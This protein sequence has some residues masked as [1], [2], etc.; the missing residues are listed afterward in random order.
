MF[1]TGAPRERILEFGFEVAVNTVANVSHLSALSKNQRLSERWPLAPGL[2]INANK[3]E[4]LPNF[5]QK[6]I[7]IQI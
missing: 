4:V 6:I 3:V 7:Q 1:S 5:F 2:C